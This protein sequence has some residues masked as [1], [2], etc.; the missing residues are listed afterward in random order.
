MLAMLLLFNKTIKSLNQFAKKIQKK[1]FI[2]FDKI[3]SQIFFLLH[4]GFYEPW[5]YAKY[6]KKEQPFGIYS[7]GNRQKWQQH[8]QRKAHNLGKRYNNNFNTAY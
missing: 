8:L 4:T 1:F 7:T 6:Q 2:I 5:L 3:F